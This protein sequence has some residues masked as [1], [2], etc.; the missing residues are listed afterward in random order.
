MQVI[1]RLFPSLECSFI[2][3]LY[4]GCFHCWN[5]TTGQINNDESLRDS[6]T[7]VS[8]A[9]WCRAHPAASQIIITRI[10]KIIILI[11]IA[12]FRT[13]I[14]KGHDIKTEK[15]WTWTTVKHSLKHKTTYNY[16]RQC[17]AHWWHVW[18][19]VYTNRRSSYSRSSSVWRKWWWSS[20]IVPLYSS[21]FTRRGDPAQLDSSSR[22][23]WRPGMI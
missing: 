2:K 23:W 16:I 12:L 11:I 14:Y 20:Q 6:C 5:I 4:A 1:L 17:T 13:V 21:S 22:D 9:T 10:I 15:K 3:I 18:C 7:V 19:S 8:C